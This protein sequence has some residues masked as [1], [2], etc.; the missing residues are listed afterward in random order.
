MRG[1]DGKIRPDPLGDY[2]EEQ[3]LNK[4][5]SEMWLAVLIVFFMFLFLIVCNLTKI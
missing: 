4:T 2:R 3:D 1:D 5:V